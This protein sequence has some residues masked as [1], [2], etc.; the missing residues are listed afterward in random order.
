M[1][2]CAGLRI[3]IQLDGAPREAVHFPSRG[4][5]QLLREGRTGYASNSDDEGDLM[6]TSHVFI[7]RYAS[8]ALTTRRTPALA[9]SIAKSRTALP[10]CYVAS[11][12]SA[13]FLDGA[14]RGHQI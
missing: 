9:W 6:R 4:D 8:M 1:G 5:E 11:R 7:A 3:R 13:E 10:Q 12:S 2:I 14:N